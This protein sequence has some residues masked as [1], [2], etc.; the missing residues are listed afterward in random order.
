MAPSRGEDSQAFSDA[1]SILDFLGPCFH[2]LIIG[3]K[4]PFTNTFLLV[5][6]HSDKYFDKKQTVG[7]REICEVT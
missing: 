7:M 4:K 2:F 5:D 6:D 1:C 3:K